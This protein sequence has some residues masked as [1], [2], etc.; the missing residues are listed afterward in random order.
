ML[1]QLFSARTCWVENDILCVLVQPGFISSVFGWFFLTCDTPE[2][3]DILRNVTEGV[4]WEVF[5]DQINIVKYFLER[6]LMTE[7]CRVASSFAF[8]LL[9]STLLLLLS[10]LSTIYITRWLVLIEEAFCW[11]VSTSFIC[12]EVEILQWKCC[13]NVRTKQLKSFT[14]QLNAAFSKTVFDINLVWQTNR[15]AFNTF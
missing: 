15:V 4:F 14:A 7:D 12:L 3:A 1:C 13:I 5:L 11:K 2:L 9:S 8:L 6:L 10:N